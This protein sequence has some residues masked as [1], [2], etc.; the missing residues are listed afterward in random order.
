VQVL[1]NSGLQATSFRIG[2]ISGPVS[3]GYWA[4]TDWVAL[5]TK[6]SVAMGSF[7][8]LAGTASWIPFTA[9]SDAITD[10]LFHHNIPPLALN[11]VHPRPAKWTSIISAIRDAVK[12]TT[13]A[14]TEA[15]LPLIPFSQWYAEL[16]VAAQ[17]ASEKTLQDMVCVLNVLDPLRPLTNL[18]L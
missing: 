14:V 17:T 7:P 13:K 18:S 2:Q 6:S 9:V 12:E 16:E 8:N 1:E 10:T 3:S 5:L 4:T 11:V 15:D